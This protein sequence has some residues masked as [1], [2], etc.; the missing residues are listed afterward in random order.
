VERIEAALE[1]VEV[2]RGE[3]PQV[4]NIEHA[5]GVGGEG[6]APGPGIGRQ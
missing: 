3:A 2:G 6:G 5:L 4:P 1:G